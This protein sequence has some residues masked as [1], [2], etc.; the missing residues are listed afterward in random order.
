M[1]GTIIQPVRVIVKPQELLIPH[2]GQ[3]KR[4]ENELLVL[5][6]LISQRKVF[7]RS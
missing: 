6:Q 1:D 2:P 7:R 5:I 3:E 4:I